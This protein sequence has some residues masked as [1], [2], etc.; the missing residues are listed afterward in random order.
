[1]NPKIKIVI[2]GIGGVG[3]YFGGLLAQK[4]QDSDEVAVIFVARGEHLKQIQRK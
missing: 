2:V 4:Y 1:M 3:G